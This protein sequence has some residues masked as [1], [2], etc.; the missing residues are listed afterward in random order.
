MQAC[1]FANLWNLSPGE[2]VGQPGERPMTVMKY[3]AARRQFFQ[4]EMPV[5]MTM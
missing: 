2:R 3:I 4:F 5:S 1:A